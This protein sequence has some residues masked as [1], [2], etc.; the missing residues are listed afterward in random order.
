[1]TWEGRAGAAERLFT[2]SMS[3][4]QSYLLDKRHGALDGNVVL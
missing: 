1:V 4:R 3:P 2:P